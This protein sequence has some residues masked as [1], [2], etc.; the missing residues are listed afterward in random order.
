MSALRCVPRLPSRIALHTSPISR[1]L[2]CCCA[3]TASG[4]EAAALLP[5]S[6]MNSR[7]LMD[8]ILG[9]KTDPSISLGERSVV[10]H[11]KIGCQCPLWVIS[12]TFEM[13]LWVR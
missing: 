8:F 11:S 5:K 7:R 4:Q 12:V 9:P 3:R 6:V 13:S 10:R 1:S 2:S